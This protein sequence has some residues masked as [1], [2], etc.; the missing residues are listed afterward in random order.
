MSDVEVAHRL[1]GSANGAQYFQRQGG[2]EYL[3]INPVHRQD[4][5]QQQANTAGRIASLWR[6]EALDRHNTSATAHRQHQQQ[7]HQLQLQPQH[8][9]HRHQ[10][11]QN[12]GSVNVSAVTAAAVIAARRVDSGTSISTNHVGGD[13]NS[14]SDGL[15][16]VVR[17]AHR[18]DALKAAR[19]MAGG[20]TR[21]TLQQQQQQQQ[22][23]LPPVVGRREQNDWAALSAATQFTGGLGEFDFVGGAGV[24]DGAGGF[25]GSSSAAFVSSSSA[26]I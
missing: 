26:I 23:R 9:Q 16:S 21:T 25:N 14:N 8:Q 20:G 5:Y 24:D 7:P 4:H 13:E 2:R 3:H 6:R 1:Q 17:L 15:H 12:G 11:Q 10:Q 22:Q 19:V 18:L